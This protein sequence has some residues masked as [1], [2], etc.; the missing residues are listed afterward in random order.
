MLSIHVSFSKTEN[1]EH[2]F[3]FIIR[4]FDLFQLLNAEW[5]IAIFS[6]TDSEK[7]QNK[8]KIPLCDYANRMETIFHVELNNET[9]AETNRN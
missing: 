8:R 2:I 3:H 4:T 5:K 6:A 1:K 7:I 9:K